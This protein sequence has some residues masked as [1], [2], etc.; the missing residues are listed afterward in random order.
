MAKVDECEGH[1]CPIREQCA[2]Y[3]D[4]DHWPALP[5]D[6]SKAP[7]FKPSAAL[8]TCSMFVRFVEKGK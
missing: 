4:P 1:E 7:S 6:Y 8:E 3:R 5:D 2:C